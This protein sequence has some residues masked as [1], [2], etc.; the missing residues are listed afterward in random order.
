[1][2]QAK[3]LFDEAKAMI[4]AS[5]LL[6]KHFRSLRDA[7]HFDKTFSKIEPQA[8]D[9]EKLDGLST[10]IGVF[11]EIHELKDYKL[12]NVIKNSRGSRE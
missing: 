1:M 11:D 9:S 2:K 7:I 12:I 8:S 10:H 5:P 3:L 6:R 4:K